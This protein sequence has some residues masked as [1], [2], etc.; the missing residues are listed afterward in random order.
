MPISTPIKI[1][2]KVLISFGLLALL[3]THMDWASIGRLMVTVNPAGWLA[4]LLFLFLQIIVLGWRW[5]MMVNGKKH[6]LTYLKALRMTLASHVANIFFISSVSGIVVRIALAKHHGLSL[7]RAACA[8]IADRAM[9]LTALIILAAVFIAP[10]SQHMGSFIAR[11]TQW[12]SIIAL[13]VVVFSLFIIVPLIIQK[14]IGLLKESTRMAEILEYFNDI[15]SDPFLLFAIL[16]ASLINQIFYFVAIFILTRATGIEVPMLNIIAI[17]PV[18]ILVSSLPISIGGWGVREGA[19]IYGLGMI[20]V[21]AESA[22][23][24]SVQIGLLGTL[25]VMIAGIPAILHRDI[26]GI[27]KKKEASL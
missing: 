11:N 21:N 6:A 26:W 24:I 9:T 20:G 4:A 2:I 5:K 17:L 10:A 1:L 14:L 23:L 7:V 12:I 22:F 3:S 19:F 27:L 18:I 25:S 8:T 13:C 15:F 16:F